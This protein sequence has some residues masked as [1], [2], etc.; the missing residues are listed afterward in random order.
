MGKRAIRREVKEK[1]RPLAGR[2]SAFFS[3]G[4]RLV[5]AAAVL[6]VALAVTLFWAGR[7][8]VAPSFLDRDGIMESF[9][10]DSYEYQR[11][12]ARLAGILKES[13]VRA[14]AAEP[15][16]AHVKLIAI[17][18]ALL[19]PLFGYSTLSAE[20]FNLFCYV[21]IL[22]LVL[23]LGRE[24]GGRRVGLAAAGV[25]AL[26][27]TFL[28]HTTQFLKD[29]L[30][31]A[32]G[33][34]LTLIV[35]TWLTRTYDWVRAAGMGALMAAATALLVL[36]RHKFGVII[37]AVAFF[38][39]VLLVVR[40]VLE[41]RLLYWNLICPLLVL[42]VGALTIFS[43]TATDRKIKQYPS[44]QG[45][46]PKAVAGPG[47]QAPAIVVYKGSVPPKTKTPPNFTDRL[48]GATE[49]IAADLSQTRHRF[50]VGTPESGSAIDREVEFRDSKDLVHYLP[51]AFQIGFWA[52]FP[53]TWLG[54]GAR[55]GNAGRLLSGAETLVIYLCQL[56]ALIAIWRDPRSLSSWL[57]LLIIIF[58]VT[59][60][61]LVVSNV[62]TLY[63][64]RYLFWMLLII[65]GA[66]G[67]ENVL[68]RQGEK[69]AGTINRG[70]GLKK[71][72]VVA[73]C[74]L[75]AA[76]SSC[77][78]RAVPAGD[79]GEARQASSGQLDFTLNNFTGTTLRAVYVSPHDSPG[80]E[81]D[82]LGGVPLPDGE[83][84]KLGFAAEER[85]AVWDIRVEDKEGKNF[86]EWKD[87]DLRGI[88]E[89]TL[90]VD[91]GIVIAEAE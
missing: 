23:L 28:L 40:Q 56:L 13:G 15:E 41:R 3:S 39:L 83:V 30:F 2:L 50:N 45:G 27:P 35:T 74:V 26:W 61:G 42:L 31:I 91:K 12:A 75:A 25:V 78:S 53:D 37:F 46:Q 51:R 77:S 20:P 11:G 1:L 4:R 49:K 57:L 38:A 52:P 67:L 59:A 14:W 81:E 88:S 68:T 24:V 71:T 29:P 60:L 90:T 76:C 86:A 21:A 32:G 47:K 69:T 58:G 6:H 72:A 16:Q 48:S 44:T 19:S 82:V 36:V 89:L 9:A 63:R 62:G 79:E 17:Q 84:V 5:V 85:A 18:F 22:C 43:L 10:F 8:Q 65:L 34:A 66:K 73:A 87:L 55:V 64:F 54:A 33:L 7:A 80:W 70:G